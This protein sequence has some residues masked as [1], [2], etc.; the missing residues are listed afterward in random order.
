MIKDIIQLYLALT[1]ILTKREISIKNV[2]KSYTIIPIFEQVGCGCIFCAMAFS[3]GGGF[4]LGVGVLGKQEGGS[5]YR[6]IQCNF[7]VI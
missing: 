4:I 7:A 5:V 3:W 1:Q 2:K 6:K